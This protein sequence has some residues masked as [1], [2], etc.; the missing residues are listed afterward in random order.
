[1]TE[2]NTYLTVN[3]L[4]KESGIKETSLRHLLKNKI[5]RKSIRRV[6]HKILIVKEDFFKLLDEKFKLEDMTN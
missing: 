5:L 2:H 3:Q 1:M 6:G 4:S